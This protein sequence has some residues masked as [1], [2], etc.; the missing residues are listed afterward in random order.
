MATKNLTDFGVSDEQTDDHDDCACQTAHGDLCDF[1]NYGD[2][3]Y[4][5]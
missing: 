3:E 4:K 1:E 5:Q 2:C